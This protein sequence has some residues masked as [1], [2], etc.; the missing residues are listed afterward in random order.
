M[1]TI[2]FSYTPSDAVDPDALQHFFQDFE[3]RTNVTVR[4]DALDTKDARDT[5]NRFAVELKGADVSQIGS[6]WLRGLVDMN[7]L[8]PFSSREIHDL[9]GKESFLPVAW[10]NALLPDKFEQYAIPWLVDVRVVCYRRDLL[11]KAGVDEQ[12]AFVTAEAFD[13]T[14]QRLQAA[15]VTIPWVV[16]TQHAWRSLHNVASWL[17]ANGSDFISSNGKR[18]TFADRDAL[19]AF[20]AY[21]RLGR[22]MPPTVRNLGKSEAEQ[23]FFEGNAAVT[24][25]GSNV[26][27]M[28]PEILEHVGFALPMGRPFV[29]GSHLVIFKNTKIDEVA[30]KFV[31]ALTSVETQRTF[32]LG[33]LLPVK[34]DAL[35]NLTKLARQEG[36]LAQYAMQAMTYGRSFFPLYLWGLVEARLVTGMAWLWEQSFELSPAELNIM[37]E[38]ELGML[39][40]RIN[41]TLE[42]L[43]GGDQ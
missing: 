16:P 36:A 27:S 26:L 29:G 22:F 14:L 37:I 43:Q 32:G 30:L 19:A 24:I 35:A 28:Q 8:R 15:G 21:Y 38:K 40:L 11:E 31:Q 2:E 13:E 23:V 4:L 3:K 25:T 12:S 34:K 42:N 17:W 1:K 20:Q 9:G 18:A 41:R 7:V 5:L 39:A 10:E 6:T 33:S